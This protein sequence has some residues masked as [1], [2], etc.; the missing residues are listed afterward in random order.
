MKKKV[1]T[2]PLTIAFSEEVYSQIKGITEK[3]GISMGEWVRGA[4]EK[5][6][7]EKGDNSHE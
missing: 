6:L 3:S 7:S 4:I 1:F 5:A 2:R